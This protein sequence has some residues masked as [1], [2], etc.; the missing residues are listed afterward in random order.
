[1]SPHWQSWA[2]FADVVRTVSIGK[3]HTLYHLLGILASY[4]QRCEAL[5]AVLPSVPGR[6]TQSTKALR[7]P[8]SCRC[9]RTLGMHWYGFCW[10]STTTFR[11]ATA[12]VTAETFMKN[13]VA[14]HGTS[15]YLRGEHLSPHYHIPPTNKHE[16]EG[17]QDPTPILHAIHSSCQRW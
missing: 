12:N 16:E 1:M 6:E 15:K 13:A 7:P 11:E 4:K 8:S 14:Y 3:L 2:Q 10:P 17:E 5:C 9:D